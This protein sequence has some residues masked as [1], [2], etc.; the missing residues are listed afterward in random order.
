MRILQ[1]KPAEARVRALAQR[2]SRLDEIE[3]TVRR[4]VEDVRRRGDRALSKY[5]RR[6]DGLGP[7]QNLRVSDSELLAAWRIAPSRLRTALRIAEKNIRRFC[8]WQKP[9]AW[10]RSA[11]GISLGQ[12]ARPLNG[13]GC[14]V[15]GGSLPL[16]SPWL[17]TATAAQVAG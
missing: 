16:G 13:C 11:N 10:V 15:P 1:G 7:K 6:F 17:T 4:I 8:E 2:S 14:S 3:P 9:K 5:A 12:L